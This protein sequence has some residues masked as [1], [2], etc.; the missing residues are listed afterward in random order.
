MGVWYPDA[1]FVG[2]ELMKDRPEGYGVT[3][4]YLPRDV[5]S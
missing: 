3:E 4:A 1:S 5:W 2:K